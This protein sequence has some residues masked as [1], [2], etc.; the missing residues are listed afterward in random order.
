MN[1]LCAFVNNK[2]YVFNTEVQSYVELYMLRKFDLGCRDYT[3]GYESDIE[4]EE[5]IEVKDY[6]LQSL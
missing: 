2:V 1:K 3:L 4:N 5:R 6:D